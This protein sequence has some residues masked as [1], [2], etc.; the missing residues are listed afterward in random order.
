MYKPTN[1]S[2]SCSDCPL[3]TLIR[4]Q[5]RSNYDY[6]ST[7]ED[8]LV[9]LQLDQT[10]VSPS[11]TQRVG[12]DPLVLVEH[13][14]FHNNYSNNLMINLLSVSATQVCLPTTKQHLSYM[15]TIEANPVA[16][17]FFNSTRLFVFGLISDLGRRILIWR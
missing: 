6:T 7:I 17:A 15:S 1:G 10:K 3:F 11:I 13:F 4:L 14:L 8:V 2:L 12:Y 9:L 16:S 5:Q